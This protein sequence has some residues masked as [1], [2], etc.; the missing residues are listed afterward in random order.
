MLSDQA[1]QVADEDKTEVE[2]ALSTLKETLANESEEIEA[3][4]KA[5][6]NLTE[7]SQSFSQKLY[8]SAAQQAEDGSS[9]SQ[10]NVDDVVDAE[11]IDEDQ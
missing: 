4:R 8:E 6:E 10:D 7:V 3:I 2:A 5:T 1:E 11:I 9:G